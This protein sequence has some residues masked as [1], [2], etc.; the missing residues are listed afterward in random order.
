MSRILKCESGQLGG[1]DTFPDF[2]DGVYFYGVF[3]DFMS[4]NILDRQ[5]I[6]YIKK[7]DESIKYNGISAMRWSYFDNDMRYNT[8]YEIELK[9]RRPEII[10][11]RE[12]IVK[13]MI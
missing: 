10:D 3:D 13:E 1:D 9:L 12:K 5:N 2:K 11:D 8:Q 7:K 4:L 6:I